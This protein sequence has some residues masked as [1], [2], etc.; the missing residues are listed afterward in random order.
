M[1]WDHDGIVNGPENLRKPF[2]QAHSG[3]ERPIKPE[4]PIT[5]RAKLEELKKSL[6]RPQTGLHLEPGGSTIQE[7]RSERNAQRQAAL[8]EMEE[9]MNAFRGRARDT[10][11]MSQQGRDIAEL[12]QGRERER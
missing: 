10:F 1:H 7:Y 12:D 6:E 9:R 8:R 2:S 5:T 11:N 4:R 3:A